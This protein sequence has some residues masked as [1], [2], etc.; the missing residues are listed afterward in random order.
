MA[1]PGDG[2]A[3]RVLGQLKDLELAQPGSTTAELGALFEVLQAAYGA[4]ERAA[5]DTVSGGPRG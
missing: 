4:Q 2:S 1:L 3:D 5:D